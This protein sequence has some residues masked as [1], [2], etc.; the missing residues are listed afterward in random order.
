MLQARRPKELEEPLA[1]EEAATASPSLGRRREGLPRVAW[2]AFARR[3][4]RSPRAWSLVAFTAVLVLVLWV[5]VGVVGPEEGQGLAAEDEE[6]PILITDV[7]DVSQHEEWLQVLR[8][9]K[10]KRFEVFTSGLSEKYVCV[11]ESGHRAAAKPME[12]WHY[13]ARDV[14]VWDWELMTRERQVRVS[15][16]HWE[17]QGWSEVLG[18][19]LDQVLGWNLK[20][21]VTGRVL[22]NKELY[23]FDYAPSTLVRRLLPEHGVAVSM[24]A[25]VDDLRSAVPSSRLRDVLVMHKPALASEVTEVRAVSTKIVFDYLIDDHDGSGAQNYKREGQGPL[26]HWDSGLAFRH[27]PHGMEGAPK[28]GKV[29]R[30][31]DILCGLSVWRDRYAELVR[32]EAKELGQPRP[33]DVVCPRICRF[34]RTVIEQLHEVARNSTTARKVGRQDERFQWGL[35]AKLERS[36][37]E[38]PTFPV[39][40]YGYFY[41]DTHDRKWL[42][43]GLVRFLPDNFW[44][45]IERRVV[46]LLMHVDACIEKYG[47]T[48]VLL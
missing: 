4:S 15:R 37:R 11:F 1:Q 8:E 30:C 23:S 16:A 20:P 44:K 5:M 40:Q 7:T 38:D 3:A 25:W 46:E 12:Q 19:H 32:Q 42:D 34:S 33:H 22:S 31:T 39:T 35:G 13:F 28:E 24:H 29:R 21:P 18:Y 45:G 10:I 17:Y 2:G 14:P 48:E 6:E 26:L 36:L 9:G 47:R 41:T 27:G 43:H